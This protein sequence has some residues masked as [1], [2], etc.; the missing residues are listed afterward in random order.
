MDRDEQRRRDRHRQRREE[1]EV[2]ERD[3]RV[4]RWEQREHVRGGTGE[5][6]ERGGA[7]REVTVVE[8]EREQHRR[9]ERPRQRDPAIAQEQRDRAGREHDR[10]RG[11]PELRATIAELQKENELLTHTV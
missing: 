5:H 3:R 6:H 11:E 2:G 1:S 9:L 7:Q 4:D 8:P 10:E